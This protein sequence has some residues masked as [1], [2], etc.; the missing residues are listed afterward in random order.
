MLGGGELVREAEMD[1]E[2]IEALSEINSL[3]GVSGRMAATADDR[4]DDVGGMKALAAGGTSAFGVEMTLSVFG[5]ARVAGDET[6][7]T[8]GVGRAGKAESLSTTDLSLAD[9]VSTFLACEALTAAA[10][11]RM[12]GTGFLSATLVSTLAA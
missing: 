10:M 12:P 11:L 6:E 9:S 1:A 4:S 7:A 3:A 5:A 2:M 8:L